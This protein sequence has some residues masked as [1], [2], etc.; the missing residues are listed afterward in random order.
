MCQSNYSVLNCASVLGTVIAP[1]LLRTVDAGVVVVAIG[2]YDR[3]RLERLWI[4]HWK[5]FSLHS[6]SLYCA[7]TW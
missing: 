2:V 4:G 7:T 3:R 5:E 1:K 6:S